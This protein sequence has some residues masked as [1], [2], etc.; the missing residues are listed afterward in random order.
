MS[1]DKDELHDFDLALQAA[2]ADRLDVEGSLRRVHERAASATPADGRILV[3]VV[4]R[5]ALYRNAV[6]RVLAETSDIRPGV[7]AD[8][9]ERFAAGHQPPGGVVLLSGDGLRAVQS[10]RE[11][12]GSGHKVLVLAANVIRRGVVDALS[13]GAYGYMSKDADADEV[14]TAIRAIADGDTYMSPSALHLV[15]P[16]TE[17]HPDTV[18][19]LT[20]R[21]HRVLSMVAA[22]RSVADIAKTLSTSVDVVR[23]QLARARAKAW[24]HP[25]DASTAR[26]A[27]DASDPRARD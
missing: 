7:V 23:D 14:L 3:G 9:V 11:L 6:A 12:T 20:E 5:H 8:T 22:G 15:Y 26:P 21:E 24:P 27:V 25:A 2:V 19:G 17:W 18:A 13:A 4:E 1:D 16:P 10:L